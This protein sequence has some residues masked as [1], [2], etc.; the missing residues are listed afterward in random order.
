M[1]YGRSGGW[2]M[3]RL[4]GWAFLA[5]AT[6][7]WVGCSSNGPS[8]DDDSAASPDARVADA[9]VADARVV[10]GAV[11]TPDAPP[12]PPDAHPAPADAHPAPPDAS[13]PPDAAP[14]PPPLGHPFGTHSGYCG[15]GVILPSNHTQAQLDAAVTTFYDA[16][17]AR[18]IKPG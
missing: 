7:L 8:G 12:A 2:P 6:A 1:A 16:W 10:D 15:Q 4:L 5:G 11:G 18:Y 9:S 3:T 17:K 13:P 14:P